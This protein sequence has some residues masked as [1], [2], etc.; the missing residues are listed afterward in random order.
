ME[1]GRDGGRKR[2]REEGM[3]GG[4]DGGRKRWR[5]EGM[6]GGRGKKDGGAEGWTDIK[7]LLQKELH[8][9]PTHLA[10]D[11]EFHPRTADLCLWRLEDGCAFTASCAPRG[12]ML[13]DTV[14]SYLEQHLC[15]TLPLVRRLGELPDQDIA[16][17]Q[18]SINDIL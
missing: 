8:R 12:A 5:E 16:G 4:M 3:E 18:I 14:V 10:C 6:E 13:A 17:F 1:G 2:W 7:G 15:I 11:K 9:E